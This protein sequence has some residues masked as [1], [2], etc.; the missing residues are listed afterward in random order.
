MA[1][2][3]RNFAAFDLML[4]ELPL[5]VSSQQGRF[6]PTYRATPP[7][8]PGCGPRQKQRADR[9]AACLRAV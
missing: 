3:S 4:S 5:V 6:K 1:P 7:V 9:L 2:A 8:K